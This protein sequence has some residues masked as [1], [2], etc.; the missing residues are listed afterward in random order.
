VY[1]EESEGKRRNVLLRELLLM[2]SRNLTPGER[3]KYDEIDGH[4]NKARNE[5]LYLSIIGKEI[6][7]RGMPFHAIVDTSRA[8]RQ[9]IR[10][11]WG[12]WCNVNGA[13]FGEAP[14]A[15][16]GDESVDAFVWAKWGGESDGTSDTSAIHYDSFC[17]KKDA[18]QPMPEKGE[19]SLGYFVMLLRNGK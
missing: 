12:D 7:A 16:T 10:E 18:F 4:L 1:R 2:K 15:D 5:Q 9:G 17:G 6:R 19:W 11:E 14:S 13:G 3:F 8:G